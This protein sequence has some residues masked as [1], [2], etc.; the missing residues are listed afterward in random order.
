[1]QI[2]RFYKNATS[3]TIAN[4]EWHKNNEN[5]I[6]KTYDISISLISITAD[7]GASG[8]AFFSNPNVPF[9][10]LSIDTYK[11]G[12]L[13][14]YGGALYKNKWYGVRMVSNDFNR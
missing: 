7:I 4:K 10:T 12:S 6:T 3:L 2:T 13:D 11:T 1:M 5:N 9:P 8:E 14:F